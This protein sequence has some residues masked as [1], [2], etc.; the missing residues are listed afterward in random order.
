MT[1]FNF[2]HHTGENT[3]YALILFQEHLN[4]F[5]KKQSSQG[6]FVQ[7]AYQ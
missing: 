7:N 3:F 1:V 5:Y 4:K 6:I 2:N